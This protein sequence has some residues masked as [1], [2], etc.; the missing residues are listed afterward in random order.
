MYIMSKKVTNLS[1]NEETIF[2]NTEKKSVTRGICF[3]PLKLST[4]KFYKYAN[5][6]N[7]FRQENRRCS[8]MYIRQCITKK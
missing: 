7:W 3:S 5:N 4:F 6:N 1:T 8:S 2:G